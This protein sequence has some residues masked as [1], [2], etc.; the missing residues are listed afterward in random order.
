M[1]AKRRPVSLSSIRGF[2]MNART[3]P[4][5]NS[6][7]L[8]GALLLA[9]ACG[10]ESVT[11]PREGATS[12]A[13]YERT[14]TALSVTSASPPFGDQGTT[15]DVHVFGTGFTSDAKATWLL[16][17]VADSLHVRTNRTTFVSS[18]EV[19]ANVTIAGDATLAFWDVQVALAGGIGYAGRRRVHARS[20]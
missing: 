17:G 6:A 12:P 14:S 7:T 19:V 2:H 3:L 5:L 15:V 8:A 10:R 20:E 4:T 13:L 16:H 1:A 18:T 11:T 9:G